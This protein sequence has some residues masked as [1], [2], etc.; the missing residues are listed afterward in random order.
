MEIKNTAFTSIQKEK[1]KLYQSNTKG[2]P[3]IFKLKVYG[4][5][6]RRQWKRYFQ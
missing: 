2:D 6:N 4:I 1:K 3:K 5:R